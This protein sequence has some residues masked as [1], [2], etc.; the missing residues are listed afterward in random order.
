[1]YTVKHRVD[2]S[3]ERYKAQLVAKGFTQT[4]GI[5][6]EETFALV[7]KMNSIKVLIYLAA[8]LDWPLI[9]STWKMSSCMEIWKKKFIC[10]FLQALRTLK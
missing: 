4:Y 3:N 9:N 5:N 2:G 6:Y 7:A 1:M 10:V 8:N